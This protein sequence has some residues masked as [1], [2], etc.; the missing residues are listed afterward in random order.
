MYSSTL[1]QGD[2]FRVDQFPHD[3][4]GL[5]VK[6][7]ILANR[8]PR[9][10][11]D[12]AIYK[13][14]LA[15]QDDSQ[16]STKDAHGQIVEH[17]TVPDFTYDADELSF[18]FVPLM[19]GTGRH[20]IERDRYLQVELPV[21]RL[22]GHYDRSIMPM[23]AL[24]N[25]VAIS[26]LPRNFNSASASAEIM[27]SIAFVQVGIRL[28]I[29]SRLPSVGYPIKMQRVLN[30]CFW[31]LCALVLE[32]NLAFFLVTKRGWEIKMT[33][34]LDMMVACMALVYTAY[35]LLLYYGGRKSKHHS[36]AQR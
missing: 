31:L 29:D 13:I 26:C 6:I 1:F 10:R 27:L 15:T 22:S 14:A 12:K 18:A 23:L 7:G 34:R 4:H 33:D 28:T 5:Q 16:G 17:V 2:H 8:G 36:I 35:I 32:S 3:Q 24:L 19:F 21:Y 11:W 9:G 20:A 30:K 25:I